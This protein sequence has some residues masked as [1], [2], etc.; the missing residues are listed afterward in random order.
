[1]GTVVLCTVQIINIRKT[2]NLL[3][4][5]YRHR[6]QDAPPTP[7]NLPQQPFHT[8]TTSQVKVRLNEQYHPM[9]FA[10]TAQDPVDTF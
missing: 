9:R 10:W 4:H 3:Y 8:A 1:M 7:L 5:F 6:Y 2:V